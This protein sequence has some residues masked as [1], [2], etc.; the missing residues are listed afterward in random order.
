[1]LLFLNLLFSSF[2]LGAAWCSVYNCEASLRPNPDIAG[3]SQENKC[4]RF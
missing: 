2:M 3:K 4:F 1:M